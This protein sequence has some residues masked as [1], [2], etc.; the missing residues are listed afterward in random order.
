MFASIVSAFVNMW[1]NAASL[2]R[3][4]GAL[5]AQ[6]PARR[7]SGHSRVEVVGQPFHHVEVGIDQI[8]ISGEAVIVDDGVDLA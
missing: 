8:R 5:H 2:R 7:V 6:E 3:A 4:N 1:R